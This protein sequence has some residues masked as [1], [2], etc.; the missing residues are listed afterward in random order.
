M[1]SCLHS[2]LI[3]P[4]IPFQNNRL[5]LVPQHSLQSECSMPKKLWKNAF[6]IL[7]NIVFMR[8][9]NWEFAPKHIYLK[10]ECAVLSCVQLFAAPWTVACQAPLLIGFFRQEYWSRLPCPPPGDLPNP[11]IEPRS[12]TLQVDS[13]LSQSQ[14][15]KQRKFRQ[16]IPVTLYKSSFTKGG[17]IMVIL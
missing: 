9:K 8:N 17:T 13:L 3:V 1:Q 14:A 4:H 15:L 12:P 11:G 5:T 2:E 10:Y 6:F 7:K 16:I